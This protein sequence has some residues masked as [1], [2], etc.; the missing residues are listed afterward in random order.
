[1]KHVVMGTA[2]H[3]D[4]GKTTLVKRLTG[5]DTDRLEE[6]KRR[7][8]TI[9]LG[10]APLTLPS[11]N[12]VS[13]IDVPGHEKFVKT[14]VAGA[15]GIDFVM[16]VIAAD[17]GVMP[18][19]EEHLEILS[20]LGVRA[21]VVAIAKA[22]LVD[23][24]WLS[25]VREDIAKTLKG[26]TLEGIGM[27][28][29]SALTGQG[30]DEL[31]EVLEKLTS[32]AAGHD[33]QKLFR[34]PVDRVFTM[35]GYGT[36]VTGTIRGGSVRRGEAIEVLPRG[37]QGKVRGIQ[38]H[39]LNADT[40]AAG[41]RC[42]LNIAGVEK[43]EIERGDVVT[44]PG[45][46]RPVS[47]VDAVVTTVRNRGGITHNQRVHFHTGTSEVLA[48]IRVLDRDMIDENSRGYAQI[49]FESPVAAVRGDRFIIRSY[50]P[51]V[52]L[53]GGEIIFHKTSNR[54]RFA[55][56]TSA[57]LQTGESGSAAEVVRYILKK[58]AGPMSIDDIWNELYGDREILRQA[59]NDGIASEEIYLLK[60]TDKYIDADVKRA[61]I[62]KIRQEFK[63]LYDKYPFRFQLDREQIKNRVFPD[64][65]MKDYG[66]LLS[67]LSMEGLFDARESRVQE[68]DNLRFGQILAGSETRK[69]EQAM[70]RDGF[71]L[72][73]PEMLSEELGI[74]T[75]K[76]LEIERF[77]VAAGRLADLGG[78]MM[79]HNEHFTAAVFELR[80]LMEERGRV[81]TGEVR[82]RLGIGRKAAIAFLEHL[83]SIGITVREDNDRKPGVHYLDLYI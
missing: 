25:A 58:N 15:T 17:E 50:S 78:N 20:I 2:G 64:M 32:E 38:V 9:E 43:N 47:L 33:P 29:V 12:V 77:L 52:T 75:W 81:T 67:M 19:T 71:A 82:D 54:K 39:G 46:V 37:T 23:G 14:M 45:T 28:P 13:I 69:V 21:G 6:E 8:M 61:Y 3:I 42:A 83:D 53:G 30:I 5:V 7:G 34:L 1:M 36:V 44:M 59:I 48:R 72:K 10:F 51:M 49:R 70:E 76:I 57:I 55:P 80:S 40:A 22:E 68:A 31:L 18:Q 24:D 60:A 79:I 73:N 16:L 66:A 26:T 41:D 56:E 74:N 35:P 63:R 62:E 11:G 4:H 65:D 27:I